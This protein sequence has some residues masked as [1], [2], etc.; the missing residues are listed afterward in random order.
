MNAR[1]LAEFFQSLERP[2]D[3]GERIAAATIITNHRPELEAFIEQKEREE[4]FLL[5]A[6]YKEL[7]Q[8]HE[9]APRGAKFDEEECTLRSGRLYVGSRGS[10][11]LQTSMPWGK[12]AAS[13][14]LAGLIAGLGY[15]GGVAI[16]FAEELD[17]MQG[18]KMELYQPGVFRVRKRHKPPDPDSPPQRHR[19]AE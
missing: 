17:R 19:D 4:Q 2:L 1:D 10:F 13:V 12:A 6:H 16:R 5:A 3:K 7:L 14:L 18:E 11:T 15:V 9:I 8:R